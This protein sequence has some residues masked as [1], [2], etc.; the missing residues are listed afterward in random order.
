[1][2][3]YSVCSCVCHD[4]KRI[5]HYRSNGQKS[6][7]IAI[8]KRLNLASSFKPLPSDP[9]SPHACRFGW[10]L[11]SPVLLWEGKVGHAKELRFS[12]PSHRP[13]GIPPL[14]IALIPPRHTPPPPYIAKLK[15]A[16]D[17]KLQSKRAL[18]P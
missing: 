18:D 3:M 9:L 4:V 12:K 5:S 13:P 6:V 8:L 11:S 2:H 17:L 7:K 1:M 16:A 10:R 15:I 14:P